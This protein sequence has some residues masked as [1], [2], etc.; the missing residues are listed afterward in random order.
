MQPC[1]KSSRSSKCV[2][3]EVRTTV[4]Q[5]GAGPALVLER[6]VGGAPG[7]CNALCLGFSV[8]YKVYLACEHLSNCNHNF[9]MR[10][11]FHTQQAAK[12]GETER[13]E[14]A[15]ALFLD[16]DFPVNE[17]SKR[18]DGQSQDLGPA[19]HS[20]FQGDCMMYCVCVARTKGEGDRQRGHGWPVI[21]VCCLTISQMHSEFG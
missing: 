5:Q 4:I 1:V 20:W 6:A 19:S 16:L 21:K 3:S 12:A 17:A 11:H 8:F 13:R 15:Q 10:L 9:C 18:T 14:V 2:V 7:C